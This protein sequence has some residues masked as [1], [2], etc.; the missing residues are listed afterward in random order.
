MFF[1][2]RHLIR[3]ISLDLGLC[4]LWHCLLRLWLP[5]ISV[6]SV[7]GLLFYIMFRVT[8]KSLYSLKALH[9]LVL[10]SEVDEV[11][12]FKICL[13]YWNGL[14][15]DLYRDRYRESPLTGPSTL[16]VPKIK[17]AVPPRR[18]FYAEVLT[19]VG[20]YHMTSWIDASRVS[21]PYLKEWAERQ[22]NKNIYL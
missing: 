9:Y 10:I 14:S 22:H 11:E 3:G 15:A 2:R 16:F 5:N 13:E 1:P 8:T 7:I 12:I 20:L 17:C 19:K 21:W 4:I 18:L 6:N